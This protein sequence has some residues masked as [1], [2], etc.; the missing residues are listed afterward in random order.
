MERKLQS[1]RGA[2]DQEWLTKFS[3]TI[4]PR[5]RAACALLQAKLRHGIAI[6]SIEPQDIL[7]L[8]RVQCVRIPMK[9]LNSSLSG[10]SVARTR[11]GSLPV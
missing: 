9:K 3:F 6:R 2:H 7:G 8:H 5:W 10:R 11:P 1:K 4:E